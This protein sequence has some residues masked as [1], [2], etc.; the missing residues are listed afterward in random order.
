MEQRV[1]NRAPSL[2][3]AV[4]LGG[5]VA[6]TLYIGAAALIN[7]VSPAFIVRF[8]AGGVLGKD[9]LAGGAGVAALGVALQVVMSLIIAAVYVCAAQRLEWL[10]GTGSLRDWRTASSCSS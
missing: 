4:V 7:W 5:L 8:V 10:G 1:A 3:A 6:G 2:L 9:A